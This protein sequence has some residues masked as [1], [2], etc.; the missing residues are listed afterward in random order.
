M[1]EHLVPELRFGEFNG[2]WSRELLE[3]CAV[4][5]NGRDYKHLGPGPVP[6]FGTGGLMTTVS[7]ALSFKD[8]VGVGRKGTIDKPYVLRAPFWTVDT[9]FFVTPKAKVDTQFL[10]GNCLR[11]DWKSKAES[12]GVPSLSKTAIE[13]TVIAVT[14][15]VEQRKVGT[16]LSNVNATLSQHERK[17]R[18]LKQAKASLMQ[19][20]FPAP[21]ASE[22]EIRVKGFTGGW[23]TL[24]LGK[25]SIK[26]GP[27]G[28]SLHAE[29]YVERGT[30][31][32]T[33]E[34]FKTGRLPRDG[35]GVPQVS[36]SDVARL[37]TYK[38]EVG[39]IVFSRV[40]SVDLN[41]VTTPKQVGWLFSGRVLRVRPTA[42]HEA[43]FLHAVLE[44]DHVRQSLVSRA[45]GQTMPSL[46]TQI[47]GAT[48][49]LV[50][51]T[52]AEQQAIGA[53][54]SKLDD[55]IEAEAQYV[56]KLQQVKSALLQ[57]MLV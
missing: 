42:G 30:P 12:T 29:D 22:P 34:H 41:A 28:S 57:K 53:F 27:F 39:D 37:S 43:Q 52:V 46:N 40:G 20:M 8:A 54:F 17:H 26:T 36:D 49:I 3:K 55:L 32:V 48:E 7:D 16:L 18:Q 14:G 2:D 45:V 9:L 56:S 6:V 33:T 15:I 4:V 24:E 10:F 50:A 44:T 51:P 31:I 38:L 13:Q 11:I 19:R 47:L 21:G 35:A 5:G 23:R 1:S 25:F